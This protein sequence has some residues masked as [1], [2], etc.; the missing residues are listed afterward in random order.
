MFYFYL[1]DAKSYPQMYLSITGLRDDVL[2]LVEG[3][4]YATAF[5]HR[6]D[7]QA[8]ADK[9]NNDFSHELAGTTFEVVASRF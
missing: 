8:Y 4:A 6:A 5:T 1:L 2:T 9:L 3:T 7:A